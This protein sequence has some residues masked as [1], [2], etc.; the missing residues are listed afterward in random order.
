VPAEKLLGSGWLET[1]HPADRDNLESSRLLAFQTGERY[2]IDYRI[3][4]K[5]GTY[6]PLSARVVPVRSAGPGQ[7]I[8]HFLGTS[9]KIEDET[10][11]EL[12]SLV[13]V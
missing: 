3:R 11:D 2:G 7:P 1:V 10:R 12:P 6:H 4:K 5:D 8:T 9:T 13:E